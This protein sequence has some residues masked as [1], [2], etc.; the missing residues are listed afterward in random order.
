M[1]HASEEPETRR[2]VAR[3]DMLE[4]FR[5]QQAHVTAN[6]HKKANNQRRQTGLTV[7]VTALA[8]YDRF[9]G[10]GA[11]KTGNKLL[12]KLR[13]VA[14]ALIMIFLRIDKTGCGERLRSSKSVT[15]SLISALL[16][17]PLSLQYN[18]MQS[19]PK[20]V[21]HKYGTASLNSRYNFP[22][23]SWNKRSR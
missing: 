19:N 4:T 21:C 18:L 8:R 14:L 12:T 15:K 16:H 10:N 17:L 6:E 11:S 1:A 9:S 2:A 23:M 13:R 5:C 22:N 20:T 3:L 7:E